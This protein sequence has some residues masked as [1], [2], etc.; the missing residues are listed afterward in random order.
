MTGLGALKNWLPA[1]RRKA[2]R[3]LASG[4]RRSAPEGP[5]GAAGPGTAAYLAGKAD[6][7]AL[8]GLERWA[9]GEVARMHAPVLARRPKLLEMKYKK[10]NESPFSFFRGTPGLFYRDLARIEGRKT[11]SGA[12]TILVGDLHVENFGS[13]AKRNGKLTVGLN[14]FDEATL[15]PAR[16][17]LLRMASS[18]VLAGKAAGLGPDETHGLV[19]RFARVYAKA[20]G[21]AAEKGTKGKKPRVEGAMKK[22]LKAASEA[23]Y[24]KWIDDLAPRATGGRRAFARSK[25]ILPVG[26][27]VARH[28]AG[29]YA[30]YLK[31]LPGETA[32]ELAGYRIVDMVAAVAGNSSVGRGRFRLL[33]EAEGK[34]PIVLEFK[35]QLPSVLAS[36]VSGTPSLGSEAT[37][38]ARIARTVRRK[39]DPFLSTTTM[40]AEYGLGKDGS[41]LVRRIHP[42]ER[43]ITAEGLGSAAAFGDFVD[44]AA[45]RVAGAHARGPELGGE[46]P[47]AVLASLPGPEA[48]AKGLDAFGHRYALQV[49]RD[50]MAF[51]Q[52]LQVDPLLRKR[53]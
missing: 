4:A 7:A 12:R 45:L 51:K 5:R 22:F 34:R 50:F 9:P 19:R 28:L 52:A 41:Y 25:S 43:K 27:G 23:D 33:L 39:L 29:G 53:M 14:D 13:L 17:D 47:A 48:L 21:T 31:T 18:I 44:M 3:L 37:R 8:G 35:E 11:A 38:V 16:L 1:M 49:E 2:G 42:T 24:G 30:A 10:M 36:Y 20:L 15:G 32:R 40:P 6:R 46:G 26:H